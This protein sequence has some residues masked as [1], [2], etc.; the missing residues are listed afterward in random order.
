M[1]TIFF[2]TRLYSLA[3]ADPLERN[4][5]YNEEKT[6]KI[7]IYK[8]TDGKFYGKIVWLRI[9]IAEDGKP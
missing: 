6:D 9:P 8:A 4:L 3:Q 7:Q 1:L 5:W 2:G